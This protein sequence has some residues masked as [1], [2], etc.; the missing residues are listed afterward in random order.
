MIFKFVL[1]ESSLIWAVEFWVF[2][3]LWFAK[4]MVWVRVA[5]HEN[6]GNHEND[7]N[8]EDN[9]DSCKQGVE[10]WIRG[11]H[12]NHGN[13]ENDE[14]RENPGCTPRVPQTTGLEIP[15]CP[16]TQSSLNLIY[17][18]RPRS[19]EVR[20]RPN[21]WDVSQVGF[22]HSD[23]SG[24]R[25]VLLP[26]DLRQ[27]CVAQ[28][29]LQP[30]AL[31][32]PKG[33]PPLQFSDPSF[34]F[35]WISILTRQKA[36][37]I[38]KTCQIGH[39]NLG[40][41]NGLLPLAHPNRAVTE[42]FGKSEIPGPKHFCD[43]TR[44]FP[45]HGN[46]DHLM[47]FKERVFRFPFLWFVP[48][49]CRVTEI[50]SEAPFLTFWFSDFWFLKRVQRKGPKGGV[51][52]PPNLNLYTNTVTVRRGPSVTLP[53]LS[54]FRL[55]KRGDLGKKNKDFPLC[56]TLKILGQQSKHAQKIWNIQKQY[57]K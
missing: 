49:L 56:W 5:F 47:S 48:G 17:R 22:W 12:G 44:K 10:C 53:S 40:G 23:A 31:F 4:P 46:S 51:R 18:D 43:L 45:R 2:L 24:G 33:E 7:E 50:I 3:N 13:H 54:F 16:D 37:K 26:G 15:D 32:C 42:S 20:L 35:G 34:C 25:I 30:S 8:D 11:N 36:S 19:D 41:P 6:D 57:N 29:V 9:S 39:L 52:G 27:A 28:A 55:K 14:N 21:K 1:Q 38:I